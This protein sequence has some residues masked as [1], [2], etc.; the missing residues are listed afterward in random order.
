MQQE[1]DF[2]KSLSFQPSINPVS[3]DIGD[4]S[5]RVDPKDNIGSVHDVLYLNSFYKKQE[6]DL[7]V[8]DFNKR[9]A[10]SQCTF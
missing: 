9:Q 6:H 4:K 5:M 10:E 1:A 2:V 3:R 8:S 7:L